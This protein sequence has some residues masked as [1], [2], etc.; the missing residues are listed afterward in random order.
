[1]GNYTN[2]QAILIHCDGSH[3][4][5]SIEC[6]RHIKKVIQQITFWIKTG[7]GES[8]PGFVI[9]H[10]WDSNKSRGTAGKWISW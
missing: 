9:G 2:T 3:W 10:E 7:S 4:K 8:A 1:M 5:V 6:Y